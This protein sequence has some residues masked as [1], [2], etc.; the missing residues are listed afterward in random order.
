MKRLLYIFTTIVLIGLGYF[1][2]QKFFSV[3]SIG[4]RVF[5]NFENG[6][7]YYAPTMS[8]P[9]FMDLDDMT[10]NIVTRHIL[11]SSGIVP[12]AQAIIDF[13]NQMF[14]IPSSI[15]Q[16][17]L[18]G[19]S[20]DTVSY[21]TNFSLSQADYNHFWK[22]YYKTYQDF[23]VKNLKLYS[24]ENSFRYDTI[25]KQIIYR[26]K[27][28]TETRLK[29]KVETPTENF[30]MELVFVEIDGTKKLAAVFSTKN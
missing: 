21:L 30:L 16:Y 5:K 24:K 10:T 12:S 9:L 27:T 13:K 19:S 28:T 6:K 11:L 8:G 25:N 4:E 14:Q 17:K 1:V 22:S 7:L 3:S 29:Y 15:R 20:T 18:I 23:M 2:Y 26:Q